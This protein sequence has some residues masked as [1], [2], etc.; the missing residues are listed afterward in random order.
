MRWR[1]TFLESGLL[2]GCLLLSSV[3]GLAQVQFDSWVSSEDNRYQLSRQLPGIFRPSQAP[4]QPMI[5]INP[6][7]RYQTMLGL[8]SSLE[9]STCANIRRLDERRQE[10]VLKRLVHPVEGIGINLMRICI[11]TPDFTGDPWY[12]YD[13]VPAGQTDV[14][15]EKFSIYGQFMKFIQRGAVRIDSGEPEKALGGVAFQN[16]DGRI[17]LIVANA[18]TEAQEFLILFGEM[19]ATT[20]LPARSVATYVW[21]P[22]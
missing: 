13:D 22:Q 6:G 9:P 12:S 15:L 16:P 18:G 2:T 17:A 20:S 7:R 4:K 19:A 11:G 10:E 3:A 21:R 1:W 5:R 8:G 14:P